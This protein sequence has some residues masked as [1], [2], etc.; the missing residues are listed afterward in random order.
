MG[1]PGKILINIKKR[2]RLFRFECHNNYIYFTHPLYYRTT[3]LKMIFL[4]H[5]TV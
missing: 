3:V 2:G 4:F 1:I 5:T